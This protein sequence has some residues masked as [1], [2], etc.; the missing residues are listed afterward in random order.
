MRLSNTNC[1]AEYN[2]E[3]ASW[4]TKRKDY[5]SSS[6]S[7]FDENVG[8]DGL[9]SQ[10]IYDVS[11]NALY[12]VQSIRPNPKLLEE[13]ITNSDNLKDVYTSLTRAVNKLRAQHLTNNTLFVCDKNGVTSNTYIAEVLAKKVTYKINDPELRQWSHANQFARI[14]HCKDLRHFPILKLAIEKAINTRRPR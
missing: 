13:F 3:V 7:I 11:I 12:H 8:E 14:W 10:S 2:A 4:N 9:S 5:N 6:T 1:L